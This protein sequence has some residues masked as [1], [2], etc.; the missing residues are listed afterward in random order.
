MKL[1]T[2]FLDGTLTPSARL[3]QQ[4]AGSICIAADGGIRHAARLGLQPELWL[5]DFDSAG[6]AVPEQFHSVPRQYFPPDKDKT[7]GALAIEAALKRGAQKLVLCGAFGGE[8]LDHSLLHITLA[9]ALAKKNIP[10]LLTNGET[11][12]YPLLKGDTHLDLPPGTMFSLIGL[13]AIKGLTIRGARWN[14]ENHNARLGSLHALSNESCGRVHISLRAG[15][16]ILLAKLN[17]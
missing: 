6:P 4:I 13:S 9:I 10:C 16:G 15:Y 5:G 8:R 11:E 3:R 2:I 7:D 12:G 1:F 17:L 14:L